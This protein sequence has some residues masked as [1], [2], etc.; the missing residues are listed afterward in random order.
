MSK[1]LLRRKIFT[2]KEVDI[3]V[4]KRRMAADVIIE[5]NT[6]A[7]L[8]ITRK[9]YMLLEIQYRPAVGKTIFE[10]PAGHIERNETP[11]HAAKRELEEETGFRAGKLK[12]LTHFYPSPG[13]LSKNEY[14]F[15]ATNL[16]KGKTSFDKDE[17]IATKEV[18]I[19]LALRYI[20]SG[21]IVDAKTMIAVLYYKRFIAKS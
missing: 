17:D 9:G 3:T 1:V 16:S 2:V 18:S 10:V 5:S 12:Q 8:P 14:V 21:K 13:I 6:V 7:I 15:I 20:R 11:I 4:K 19:D